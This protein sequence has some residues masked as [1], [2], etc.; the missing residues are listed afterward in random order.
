MYRGG[1]NLP[2]M[3]RH[4]MTICQI[5]IVFGIFAHGGARLYSAWRMAILADEC[6]IEKEKV[7]KL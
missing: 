3:S 6:S 5:V 2:R 7:L 1:S 4:A